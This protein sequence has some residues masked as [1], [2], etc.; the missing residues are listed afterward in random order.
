MKCSYGN[1]A[2][3]TAN[4]KLYK[5]GNELMKMIWNTW[6]KLKDFKVKWKCNIDSYGELDL[7]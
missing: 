3:I 7:N 1:S 6:D 2:H 4:K 5:D